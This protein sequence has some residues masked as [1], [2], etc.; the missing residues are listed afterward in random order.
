MELPGFGGEMVRCVASYPTSV[1]REGGLRRR[2]VAISEVIDSSG[3]I[4]AS[5]NVVRGA[6][7]RDCAHIDSMRAQRR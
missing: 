2:G 4:Q 1:T 3:V 7:V 5:I 6:R